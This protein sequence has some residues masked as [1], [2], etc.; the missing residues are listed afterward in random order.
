[1]AIRTTFLFAAAL[2]IY[3]TANAKRIPGTIIDLQG[4]TIDVVFKIPF[5]MF[6]SRPDLEGVQFRVV[7]FDKDNTR[8]VLRPDDAREIIFF[9]NGIQYRMLSRPRDFSGGIRFGQRRIFLHL[10]IDGEFKLFLHY[11]TQTSSNGPG[12]GSS[13]YQTEEEILQLRDKE[14]ISPNRIG[15]R[16]EMLRYIDDCPE[17]TNFIESRDLKRRDLGIIVSEYNKRCG[18]E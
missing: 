4:R 9:H 17:V 10:L 6:G 8:N 5:R 2:F 16:K 14:L 13:S 7:Y 18:D 15:F 1:M 3:S 12:N 11:Y